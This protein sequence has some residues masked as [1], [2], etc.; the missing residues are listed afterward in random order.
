MTTDIIYLDNAATTYPKPEAV[1]RAQDEYSRQAANPGRGAHRM[2]LN[3]ARQIYETRVQLAEFLG[4]RNVE[5]LV[6]TPG[7][8]HSINM[9]LK[10]INVQPGD[11]VVVSA[12]EHNA[13]MRPLNQLAKQRG[14]SLVTVPYARKGIVD[15]HAL[16]KTLL[17]IKPKLCVFSEA[18]NV[19]GELIDLK[20]IAA[21]CGAHK[22]PL[23]VDAAQTAGR[24][25]ASIDDYKISIWCAS[26]HKGLFGLP[27]VGLLYVA[28]EIELEPLVAGGTGSRSDEFEMPTAYPDRLEAGTSPGPAIAALSASVDWLRRTGVNNVVEKEQALTNQFLQWAWQSNAV[29]VYGNRSEAP[30]IAVVAFDIPGLSCDRVAEILDSQYGIAVRTGLH[31]APAAHMALGTLQT[32][33]VRAS[34]S[35]FNTE[36]DV[37]ALC[38]A[39]ETIA[40]ARDIGAPV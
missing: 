33:L 16:I 7:A 23:M 15:L 4:T 8:T 5:R 1:Y 34:F 6:F 31:C 20:A 27:G 25:S 22:V 40:S 37:F 10:G 9:A 18:S 21:I 17:E 39:L 36:Q 12:M 30:G 11:A 24:S 32:G 26:G 28:P 19:T 14:I 13:V 2:A 3:S 35:C 38:R 29:R